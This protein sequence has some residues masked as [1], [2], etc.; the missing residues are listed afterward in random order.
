MGVA[1]KRYHPY[2]KALKWAR[3][4]DRD[5]GES[6]APIFPEFGKVWIWGLDASGRVCA[7]TCREQ[8]VTKHTILADVNRLNA[9]LETERR[10][11]MTCS[12]FKD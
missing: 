4:Q 5:G 9:D 8:W 3:R 7:K 12:L 11:E 10:K 1:W 6:H 2:R